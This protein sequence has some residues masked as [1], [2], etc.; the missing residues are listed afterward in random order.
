MWAETALVVTSSH[1]IIAVDSASVIH[2]MPLKRYLMLT[3]GDWPKNEHN[4]QDH[5]DTFFKWFFP[6]ICI[7]TVIVIITGII[8]LV[9]GGDRILDIIT[10]AFLIQS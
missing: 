1:L 10:K 4:K 3:I 2:L 8:L 6:T 5:F 9:I 7:L